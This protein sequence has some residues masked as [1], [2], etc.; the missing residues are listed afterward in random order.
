ME[1]RYEKFSGLIASINKSIQKIKSIE[2]EEFDLKGSGVQCLFFLFKEKG[3]VSSAKLCALCQ[4]DKAAISRTLKELEAAG[5]VCVDREESRKYKNPICLTESG[6]RVGE[7]IM[8]KIDEVFSVG[9]AGISQAE[10]ESLY[11]S[12]DKIANNLKEILEKIEKSEKGT[13]R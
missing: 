11:A 12:L 9:S 8:R 10:R 13:K 7:A 5:Y 3:G 6:R 2:M 1:S 4:E